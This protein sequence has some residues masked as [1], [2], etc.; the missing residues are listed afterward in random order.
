M[1]MRTVYWKPA[2][3]KIQSGKLLEAREKFVKV[4]DNSDKYTKLIPRKFLV[5]KGYGRRNTGHRKST[6]G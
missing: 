6:K 1:F 2:G 5:E 3:G 4:I